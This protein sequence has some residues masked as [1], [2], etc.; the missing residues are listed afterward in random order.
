MNIASFFLSGAATQLMK[1]ITGLLS[2]TSIETD[3]EKTNK[4]YDVNDETNS[5]P[6]CIGLIAIQKIISRKN[7]HGK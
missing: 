2:L 7:K 5:Q 3:R 1:K 4:E 6:T